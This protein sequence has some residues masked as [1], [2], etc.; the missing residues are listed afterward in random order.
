MY[1]ISNA[2]SGITIGILQV[3]YNL[4][5]IALGYRTDFIGLV[6]F[7]G[8]IGGGLAIFPA[9]LCVDR[10]GGKAIL[11]WGSVL[12]GIA[13]AGQIILR[14]PFFLLLS[15]FIAGIGGACV[16]VVNAPFLTRNSTSE[17]RPHLFS[18]NIVLLLVTTVIGEG[19]GGILP[20]WFRSLA[21]LM[22]PLP[23]WLHWLLAPQMLA[24][25][26][27][28]SLLL[29]GLIAAPSF[30]P[31][32]LLSDDRPRS[33]FQPDQ[34]AIPRIGLKARLAVVAGWRKIPPRLLLAHPLTAM[35]LVQI[36]I[37]TGAGLLLPYFNVYFVQHLGA[38]SAL[39]GGIDA[40]A[41]TLNALLT[42]LAPW[43]VLR[44][45]KVAALVVPR[46]ISLPVMLLIGITNSL[47]LAATLYPLRQGLMDMSQGI[48]QVFSMEVVSPQH[49]GLA[50]SSYQASYQIMWAVGAS[51][52]GVV[53]ARTGYIP[54]FI[55]TT[56]LYSCALALLW[57]RFGRGRWQES[58][59]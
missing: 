49:R 36:L 14:T 30:I 53:I 43:L 48:L 35:I 7:I 3:L 50:N 47:P 18:L 55:A 56:I 13:G 12:V 26:Y 27:Q 24:R 57:S 37:G 38:T 41:N 46:V 6:L 17:E 40:A 5:L 9:G 32:F 29:A 54:V 11:I 39:F 42:L 16:L 23:I 25:S 1:L 52:G 28:L 59:S 4:Y 22:A 45:G 19:L 58:H 33:T 44:I 51:I 2:L 34:V 31:L 20:L 15:A 10:F 21:W 8:T